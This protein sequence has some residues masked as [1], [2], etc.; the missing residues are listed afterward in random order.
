MANAHLNV[1]AYSTW[2]EMQGGRRMSVRE[3]VERFRTFTLETA[4][5]A[6]TRIDFLLWDADRA[7]SEVQDSIGE[8]LLGPKDW[9]TLVGAARRSD[10]KDVPSGQTR[11]LIW[12]PQLVL[13]AV[14]VAFLEC[15][16]ALG[17]EPPDLKDLAIGILGLSD[18]IAP[19]IPEP[20]TP[21]ADRM[22]RHQLIV[23]GVFNENERELTLLPL[24]RRIYLDEHADLRS[25]GAYVN[26]AKLL[27]RAIKLDR[28]TLLSIGTAVS[29]YWR[30]RDKAK[31]HLGVE[32]LRLTKYLSTTRITSDQVEA[33]LRVTARTPD[34]MQE[35]IRKQ[36]AVD[37]LK[38]FSFVSIA[39]TPIVSIDGRQYCLSFKLLTRR[40]STDLHYFFV[41]FLGE[42]EKQKYFG[43]HG[44]VFEHAVHQT[45]RQCL[46]RV[47]RASCSAPLARYQELDRCDEER[48]LPRADAVIVAGDVL[49][50]LDAKAGRYPAPVFDG[51]LPVLDEY[52]EHNLL[53]AAGQIDATVERLGNGSLVVPHL[54]LSRVRRIIPVVV[55]LQYAGWNPLLA[56]HVASCL[57]AK[58]L[59]KDPR[60]TELQVVELAS[61]LILAD[62]PQRS[63]LSLPALFLQR[64]ENPWFSGNSF[65]NFLVALGDRL[66]WRTPTLRREYRA[67]LDDAIDY[68]RPGSS[69]GGAQRE[70][71]M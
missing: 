39:Q 56:T 65:H 25:N 35:A 10:P 38:P 64:A 51:D 53:K 7:D 41:Q 20:R 59:L 44:I 1:A 50:V 63:D 40:L 45:F 11:P 46:R 61:L 8:G 60:Y 62:N 70:T 47:R 28:D 2:S 37:D 32:P 36:Y 52:L 42:D 15:P 69:G 24:G 22:L 71:A 16:A 17:G 4:I 34:A 43:F 57:A 18:Y 9:R 68:M 30:T 29:A 33:F 55:L 58:G 19:A 49:I 3:I 27:E 5:G 13:N 14:K 54:N 26:F 23:N 12:F 21:E 6:L 48:Q 67:M 66:S 31:F